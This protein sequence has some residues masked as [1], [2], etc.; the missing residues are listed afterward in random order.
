MPRVGVGTD[1]HAEEAAGSSGWPQQKTGAFTDERLMNL[2]EVKIWYF[3][4][5]HCF[6]DT[7]MICEA[8]IYSFLLLYNTPFYECD[9]I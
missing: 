2:F 6:G 4:I 9:T 1:W 3:C 8:V 5:Q 7:A